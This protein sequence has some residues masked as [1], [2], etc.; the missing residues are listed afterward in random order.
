MTAA[1]KELTSCVTMTLKNPNPAPTAS[2]DP[3]EPS[4]PGHQPRRKPLPQLNCEEYENVGQWT[5]ET[6]KQKRKRR[7]RKTEVEG[8]EEDANPEPNLSKK[9]RR[10]T[11][12]VTS[13]FMED[14]NGIPV[15]LSQKNAV[16]AR[17]RSFFNLFLK[18]DKIPAKSEEI[19]MKTKDEFIS[20]MEENYFFLRLCENHWKAEQVLRIC[21]PN[22]YNTQVKKVQK[23][24]KQD[25]INVDT[26]DE[27]DEDDHDDEEGPS[28]LPQLDNGEADVPR[29][30]EAESTPTGDKGLII[31]WVH[32][33][34]MVGSETIRPTFTQWVKGGYFSKVPTK[35]PTR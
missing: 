24:A 10:P 28:K 35:V 16:R 9:R 26:E 7:G 19:D 33:E 22:W 23:A 1:V 14:E 13:S 11:N 2:S 3:G 17:A 30:E 5:N 6:Y 34:F 27:D 15:P 8:G 25:V 12:S 20:I 4:S 32:A 21:Y 29:E 31:Q 18:W